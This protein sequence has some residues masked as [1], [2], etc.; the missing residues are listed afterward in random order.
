MYI[1]IYIYVCVCVC[2]CVI[3]CSRFK[4]RKEYFQMSRFMK[5]FAFFK[6][7]IIL[8]SLIALV[9]AED[10][11]QTCMFP[12]CC[13]RQRTYIEEGL[14]IGVLTANTSEFKSH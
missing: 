8:F 7:L 13:F 10:K 11:Q 9:R 5:R 6:D 12:A 2:V 3:F 14:V 4:E 1:Y